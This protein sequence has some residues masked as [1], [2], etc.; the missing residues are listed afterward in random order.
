[1][2]LGGAEAEKFMALAYPDTDVPLERLLAARGAATAIKK[3]GFA[4]NGGASWLEFGPSQALY[5]KTP[6]R[7]SFG[8]VPNA[9]IAAGRTTALAIDPNCAPG[10][11][12]LWA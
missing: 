10:N 12:R 3:R 7:N 11:C 9:Y 8:Y 6:F 5:P 4:P 1:E 2:D